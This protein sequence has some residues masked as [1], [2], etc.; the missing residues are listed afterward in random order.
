MQHDWAY[1]T[2]EVPYAHDFWRVVGT[3]EKNEYTRP[4]N[5][6]KH[7]LMEIFTE[8]VGVRMKKDD[9]CP[10]LGAKTKQKRHT[11]IGTNEHTH[12]SKGGKTLTI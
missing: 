10:R 2:K 11:P 3:L 9:I 5:V 1:G 4:E 7:L 6:E 12:K 8:S